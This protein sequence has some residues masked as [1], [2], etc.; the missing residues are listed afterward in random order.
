M[1][2]P[3]YDE[4][5]TEL[6]ETIIVLAECDLTRDEG[7]AYAKVLH[8]AGNQVVCHEF[9]G[10]VHAFISMAGKVPQG[11]NAIHLVCDV[12]KQDGSII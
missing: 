11:Q 12:I 7:Y 5:F 10:M 8:D 4:D 9:Q 6:P 3:I 1:V 2:S